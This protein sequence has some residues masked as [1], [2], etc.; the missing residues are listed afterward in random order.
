M[1]S[2]AAIGEFFKLV[3]EKLSFKNILIFIV[4]CLAIYGVCKISSGIYDWGKSDQAKTDNV[5]INKLKDQ[6]ATANKNLKDLQTEVTTWKN[7]AEQEQTDLANLQKEINDKITAGV[8][9]A[10]QNAAY[11]EK[12]AKNKQEVIKYVTVNDDAHCVIPNGF[13]QLFNQ[14]AQGTSPD[15]STDA[16]SNSTGSTLEAPSGI[17]LSDVTRAVIINNTRAVQL[18]QQVLAW[19]T[20]YN[21]TKAAWENTQKNMQNAIPTAP[22]PTLQKSKDSPSTSSGIGVLINDGL[23]T[24]IDVSATSLFKG[25]VTSNEISQFSPNDHFGNRSANDALYSGQRNSGYLG[26]TVS[27]RAQD[28]LLVFNPSG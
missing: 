22:T 25:A 14:S 13:V 27:S 26:S 10:N 6:L 28:H 20:W 16:I 5:T 15:S 7:T 2:F 9:K 24:N 21:T 19:Q 17:S 8:D 4:L 18:Q 3:L 1:L 11:W 23:P 12:L